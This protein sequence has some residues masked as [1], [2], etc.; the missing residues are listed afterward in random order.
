MKS[1]RKSKRNNNI[2][3]NRPHTKGGDG[4]SWFYKRSNINN[5]NIVTSK[6]NNKDI[7]FYI[8]EHHI[9]SDC[10]HLIEHSVKGKFS[11]LLL[12][13]KGFWDDRCNK[14]IGTELLTYIIDYITFNNGKSITLT[15]VS[16][17][18]TLEDMD[19]YQSG[20]QY[21]A[22]KFERDEDYNGNSWYA[23]FGFKPNN[24]PSYINLPIIE[25]DYQRE[26][27]NI[28]IFMK[29]TL[30]QLITEYFLEYKHHLITTT[31]FNIQLATNKLTKPNL[32]EKMIKKITD[33]IENYHLLL[34]GQRLLIL[35]GNELPIYKN[36]LDN[37]DIEIKR[38]IQY[39][40]DKIYNND[41]IKL[42]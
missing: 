14:Y 38:F 30:L 17:F 35:E 18:G 37:N 42:L 9:P 11:L 19:I 29:K 40:Y 31:E 33:R 36:I 5:T 34:E 27:N 24:D 20:I 2:K 8:K 12:D 22:Y 13:T 32:T 21:I 1:K 26:L 4:T 6:K 15:D 28:R 41:R 16:T 39:C 10:L 25:L 23:K 3:R 7:H